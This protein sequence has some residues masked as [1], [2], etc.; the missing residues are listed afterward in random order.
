MSSFISAHELVETNTVLNT[1][2]KY[3]DINRTKDNIQRYIKKSKI[4]NTDAFPTQKEF[5]ISVQVPN[6]EET[7]VLIQEDPQAPIQKKLQKAAENKFYLET[8][9][10][11]HQLLN[12]KKHSKERRKLIGKKVVRLN[13]R[14]WEVDTFGDKE[15]GVSSEL[16][17]ESINE[18]KKLKNYLTN[19]QLKASLKQV[20]ERATH[21][22]QR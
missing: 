12:Q 6:Q 2:N 22:K 21:L 4:Q 16:K 9:N 20:V 19:E 17:E 5:Q 10:K 7:Q 15:D 11:K 3:E 18:I 13:I 14:K 1:S 8:N